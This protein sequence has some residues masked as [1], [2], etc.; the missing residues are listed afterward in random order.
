MTDEICFLSARELARRMRAR[1]V[2]AREVT[3]AHLARIERVNP[4]FNAIV[5]LVAD[6]RWRGGA[7]ADGAG[8]AAPSRRRCTA[9]R[10]RTRTCTRPAGIRTTYGSPLLADH[11]PRGTSWSSSGCARP[12][13]S[14]SGKTNVPEFGAGSHTF[15]P[16]FGA[17]R[18]PY[19]LS[20][21]AGGSSGGGAAALACGMHAARRRQRHGRLAAQPSLVL[22]R[23]RVPALAGPGAELARATRPGPRWASRGRWPARSPTPRCCCRALAGPD[24]RSPIAAGD[25]RRALRRAARPRPERRCASPGRRDL[26]GAVPVEPEVRAAL[27]P[28]AEV[29]RRRWAAS[30]EEA[31]PGPLR[32]R[33]GLPH[34]AGLAV[35]AR[36]RHAPGRSTGRG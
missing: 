14:R 20:R 8:R 10:S 23:R 29:V 25:A 17:T 9:C 12:A 4:P 2:S 19:D 3:E 6:R 24:P 33:R 30:V 26:G 13:R 28:A 36:A 31:V 7:A 32:R 34:P 18:N 15:N 22:Q 16:V 11:V 27:E 21:S 35:R 5:T 1:E